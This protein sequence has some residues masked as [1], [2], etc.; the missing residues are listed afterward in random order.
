M[1]VY[2]NF[3][4]LLITLLILSSC[5]N[6][7]ENS[8][9]VFKAQ[10]L[11]EEELVELIEDGKSLFYRNESSSIFNIEDM[12]NSI[13]SLQPTTITSHGGKKL[14]LYLEACSLDSKVILF[15]DTLNNEISIQWGDPVSNNSGT[16][17]LWPKT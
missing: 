8:K 4:I 1:K 14:W 9:S 17:V 13:K 5:D 7:D 3:K 2:I 15:I 6:C 11:N 10:N 12:P 16:K